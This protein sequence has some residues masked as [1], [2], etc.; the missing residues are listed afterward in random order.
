MTEQG[1]RKRKKRYLYNDISESI[2]KD[3]H[4][5]VSKKQKGHICISLQFDQ[6]IIENKY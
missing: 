1:L 5:E 6:K 2:E 3:S 4:Q